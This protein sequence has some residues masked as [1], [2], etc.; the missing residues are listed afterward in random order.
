VIREKRGELLLKNGIKHTSL[1]IFSQNKKVY[2]SS[3]FLEKVYTKVPTFKLNK[4]FLI[5]KKGD[6]MNKSTIYEN[7]S[8]GKFLTVKQGQ[9]LVIINEN[10]EEA[11]QKN[12]KTLELDKNMVL[13]NKQLGGFIFVLF[14]YCNNIIDVDLKQDD[15]VKLFY[16]ATYVDYKGYIIYKKSK[17]TRKVLKN[18]LNIHKNKLYKFYNK[19]IKLKIII[20]DE[21]N[22]LKL[23]NDIFIKGKIDKKYKKIHDY[24]R[25]YI[26][27]IRFLYENVPDISHKGLG[28]YFKMI[29][30]IHRQNNVLCHNPECLLENIKLMRL[31]E[32][33]EILNY[34]EKGVSK[35]IKR[36]FKVRLKDGSPIVGFFRTDLDELKSYIIINPK[37]FYGGNFD[38]PE[39]SA[40]ILKWFN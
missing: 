40:G 33:K 30:Y 16:L 6:I 10:Q 36:L 31:S 27:S 34:T 38:L 3:D 19:M 2:G 14:N 23:S 5:Y 18:I 4:L 13:W 8:T 17:I 35:L 12:K 32:L 11:I 26:N 29:P 39:G 22:N 24:S 25:L 28:S 21:N 15:I 37:V 20:L 1:L 9:R 7:K